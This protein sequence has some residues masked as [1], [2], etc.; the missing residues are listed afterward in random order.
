VLLCRGKIIF[1]WADREMTTLVL[2]QDSAEDRWRV[3]V[4]P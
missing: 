1:G 3:K 4:R 2:V